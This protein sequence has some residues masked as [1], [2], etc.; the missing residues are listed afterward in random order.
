VVDGEPK[1]KK[2]S[3]AKV[4]VVNPTQQETKNSEADILNAEVQKEQESKEFLVMPIVVMQNVGIALGIPLE[5][6][7]KE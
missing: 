2:K 4:L 1:K 7:T 3:R 5:K 6:L